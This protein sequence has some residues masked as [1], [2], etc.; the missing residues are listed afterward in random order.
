MA[1]AFERLAVFNAGKWKNIAAQIQP[2]ARVRGLF[3]NG[4]QLKRADDAL[5]VRI[6]KRIGD[7]RARK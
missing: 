1:E 5:L 3:G 7:D 4:I 6:V 2:H